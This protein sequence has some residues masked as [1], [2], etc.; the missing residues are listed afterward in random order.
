[1]RID[2]DLV[3]RIEH[4]SAEF[5][6]RQVLGLIAQV[7]VAEASSEQCDGGFLISFGHGRYVNRGMGLGLGGTPAGEIVGAVERFYGALGLP[8]SLEVSPWVDEQLLAAFAATG[9]RLERFRNVYAHQLSTVPP[10]PEVKIVRVDAATAPRRQEIISG[11]APLG[12]TAR[13]ISDE[14]CRSAGQV[15]GATDFVAL[16]DG[17]V[18]ACGSLNVVDGIGWLGGAATA[19]ALRGKG[20]QTAL[21]QHRLRLAHA[22]GCSVAAAT[23]VPNGQSARN[24]ERLGFQLLYTQA[25]LTKPL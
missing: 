11:E 7:P 8:P 25:V 2:I 23:A 18:V 15:D 4:S 17:E 1:M 14:Y 9:Y 13:L 3:R 6:R 24:L 16:I 5:A 21:V 10:A 12:S 22:V 19:T 20:L